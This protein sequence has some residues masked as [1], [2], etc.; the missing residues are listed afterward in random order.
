MTNRHYKQARPQRRA[1]LLLALWVLTPNALAE[2]I[3]VTSP[4]YW[5]PFSCK[6]NTAEEGFTIDILRAIFEPQGDQIQYI[7][8]NYA[9]ALREV[10][11]GHIHAISSAFREEVPGFTLPNLPISQDRYCFYT[12]SVPGWTYNGPDSL[13][14]L[15]VGIIQG[16]SYGAEIDEH[17]KRNP[18]GFE[19][20]SGE[21]LT[22]KL[23]RKVMLGRLDA[24][25]EDTNLVQY[26]LARQPSI[27]LHEAGCASESYPYFALSPAIKNKDDLARRFDEGLIKLH[28]SGKLEQ[29][30][31]KYGLHDWLG[32]YLEG[33]GR[34]GGAK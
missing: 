5:C 23:A 28:H 21:D 22:Q 6:A 32:H 9:R 25:V 29:I 30:M 15:K 4:D 13:A 17:I 7:N 33:R 18:A 10:R 34:A 2:V 20:H 3:K 19:V 31:R 16:Y 11:Q 26:L 14:G 12:T 27:K 1:A 24:F 8:L